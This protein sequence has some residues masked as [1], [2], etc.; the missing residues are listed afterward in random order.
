[1]KQ[2]TIIRLCHSI[3]TSGIDTGFE[4]NIK[5]VMVAINA[6]LLEYNIMWREV[7]AAQIFEQEV[8]CRHYETYKNFEELLLECTEWVFFNVRQNRVEGPY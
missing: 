7:L 1:M 4:E 6:I 2:E 8:N 3:Y 5:L